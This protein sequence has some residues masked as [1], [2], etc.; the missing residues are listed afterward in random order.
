[1]LTVLQI[2]GALGVLV[3]FVWVQLGT[4]QPTAAAYL[5]PNLLGSSVLTV[6]AAVGGNWGFLLLEGVWAL[7]AGRSLLRRRP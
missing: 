5:V 2:A 3:P 6:L 7:V 1:M 4:L